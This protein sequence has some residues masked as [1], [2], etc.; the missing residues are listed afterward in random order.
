MFDFDRDVAY[1]DQK[2]AAVNA[3]SADLSKFRSLGGK[4]LIRKVRMARR[5]GR[6]ANSLASPRCHGRRSHA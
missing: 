5:V 2:L 4:I 1:A 6:M 3:S